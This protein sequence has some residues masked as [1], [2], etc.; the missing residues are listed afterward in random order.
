VAIG[1]TVRVHGFR[2][3]Q[4][5]VRLAGPDARRETRD[6]FKDVGEAVRSTAERFFRPI[7]QASAAAYVVRSRARGIAVESRMRRTTGRR[8][9]F[10]ALQM[11]RAL[12]PAATAEEHETERRLEHAYDRVGD[13]FE[14]G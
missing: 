11:R 3:F 8:P 2:A 7:D 14:R 9:D 5:A 12:L 10:G 1:A 13:H 4:R 6:A